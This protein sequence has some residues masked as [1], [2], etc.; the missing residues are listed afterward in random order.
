ME[1]QKHTSWKGNQRR[2]SWKASLHLP[3]FDDSTSTEIINMKYVG[4]GAEI[5]GKGAEIEGF[6][7]WIVQIFLSQKNSE[8]GGII[9]KMLL[10]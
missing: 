3:S 10:Y 2:D 9:L 7:I 6:S 4:D 5:H 8:I 1:N